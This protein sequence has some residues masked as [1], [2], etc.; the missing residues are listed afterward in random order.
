MKIFNDIGNMVFDDADPRCRFYVSSTQGHQFAFVQCLD[1]GFSENRLSVP[2]IK[3]YWGLW[4][5]DDEEGSIKQ[6]MAQGGKWPELPSIDY[7]QE[8][9]EL[10]YQE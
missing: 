10:P 5:W 9:E 4:D 7:F 8:H 1:L 2:G 6:I 3:R